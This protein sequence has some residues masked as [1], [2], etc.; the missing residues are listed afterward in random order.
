MNLSF[1]T[2]AQIA[3]LTTDVIQSWTT[4]EIVTLT[5]AQIPAFRT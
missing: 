5:T 1:Y 2:T 4:S 3:V